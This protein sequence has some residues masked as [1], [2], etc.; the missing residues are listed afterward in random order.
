MPAT[1]NFLISMLFPKA[2]FF[3]VVK[4]TCNEFVWSRVK[5]KTI[6]PIHILR[7]HA[8]YTVPSSQ[9]LKELFYVKLFKMVKTMLLLSS[10]MQTYFRLS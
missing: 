9:L 5:G 8:H 2:F 7:F 10:L 6:A 1:I 3:R 4:T